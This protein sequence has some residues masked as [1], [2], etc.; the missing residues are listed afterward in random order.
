VGNG[1]V[2]QQF[3]PSAV[4]GGLTFRALSAGS[5]HTCGLTNSGVAYCWGSN[6]FGQL[7]RTI[8]RVLT[9]ILV[10]GLTGAAVLGIGS[11]SA[12]T[13]ALA[14][15]G[16]ALCWGNN[17]EGELGN[18]SNTPSVALPDSVSDGRT[19]SAIS[20]GA[21]H[22][23]AIATGGAAYC[24]GNGGLGQLGNGTFG[25][26]DTPAPVA[27]GLTFTA[28]AAGLWHSCGIAAGGAAYCWGTNVRG[29]L[30]DTTSFSATPIP[31]S[32][33]TFATIAAGVF[34]S[35]GLATT[36]TAFCWGYNSSGQVGDSSTAPSPAS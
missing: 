35:C 25:S 10:R 34:E 9:P 36:G 22:T 19:Y 16:A 18:G 1:P 32:G 33:R 30:G 31:V 24:W 12:H 2:I 3:G 11:T 26:A 14:G 7:G 21:S 29:E 6:R 28:I 13:C 5:N 15:A 20:P 4:S 27:G 23:C 17:G 8:E